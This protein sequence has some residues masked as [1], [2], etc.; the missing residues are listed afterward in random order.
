MAATRER[1]A[2]LGTQ[3]RYKRGSEKEHEKTIVP[4][5]KD[6]INNLFS[7]KASKMRHAGRVSTASWRKQATITKFSPNGQSQH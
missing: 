5:T 2:G 7:R 6:Q 1:V 3:T 4:Q